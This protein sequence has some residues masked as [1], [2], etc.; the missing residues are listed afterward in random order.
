[1]VQ[2]MYPFGKL[3]NE[4]P[5]ERRVSLCVSKLKAANILD[6]V[7]ETLSI[8]LSDI[9]DAVDVGKGRSIYKLITNNMAYIIKEKTNNNQFI[10][11][12]IATA[13]NVPS[14]KSYFRQNHE[15]FWELTEFLNEHEVFNSKKD[16]L[17]E[18]YAKAAA[19]GDFLEVG[20]RHF[21]NYI[22]RGNTIIA[23]DV[24]HLM[25][26][27]NQH[28]TKKYIA[29]GLYEICLLQYYMNDRL[30]F[31]SAIEAFFSA[32]QWHANALFDA[33]QT[34]KKTIPF[35]NALNEHWVSSKQFIQHMTD[36]YMQ[37]LND[38]LGRICYKSLL[39]ELVIKKVD[40]ESY[41]EL[42]MYYLADSHRISTF[43]GLMNCLSMSLN[44]YK[45]CR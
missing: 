37:A 10:F 18:M 8:S 35:I 36:I 38:M 41:P 21:E 14:P 11:N 9:V 27:D 7:L 29:G 13:F 31:S 32:Y 6:W 17:I 28:W 16:V 1:M 2:A 20:D 12:Q 19:F 4:L 39:Q 30:S 26:K 43:L 40:L 33:K 44:K 5:I 3:F 23:I 42:K 22:S 24:A 34:I 45:R 15:K 25:E